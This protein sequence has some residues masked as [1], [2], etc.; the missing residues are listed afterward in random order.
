LPY[1][2]YSL[3]LGSSGFQAGEQLHD[4]GQHDGG[5]AEAVQKMAQQQRQTGG[6]SRR[7]EL[8]QALEPDAAPG[9]AV[10][11]RHGQADAHRRDGFARSAAQQ[12]S[13]GGRSQ[14]P[15]GE[16]QPQGKPRP[17]GDESLDALRARLR[18]DPA[19]SDRDGDA[20]ED[21]L[22]LEIDGAAT[23]GDESDV[24]L[25]ELL[26]DDLHHARQ[27]EELRVHAE[28]GGAAAS[29]AVSSA[30]RPMRRRPCRGRSWRP[31]SKSR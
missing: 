3:R 29:C 11:D 9:K 4:R 28:A 13:Q 19:L 27:H 7:G 20:L 24:L 25:A 15:R 14:P 30:A 18:A 10:K 12:E 21:G 6:K 5:C 31:S 16:A 26:V 1:S 17:L 23:Y 22:A 8:Q 2:R